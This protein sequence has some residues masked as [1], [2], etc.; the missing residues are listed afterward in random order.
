VIGTGMGAMLSRV[1]AASMPEVHSAS[2]WTC[3]GVASFLAAVALP[4]C[5]FPARRAAMADPAE[6]LRAE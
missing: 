2:F 6:T 5:Y 1:L 4:A 3:I